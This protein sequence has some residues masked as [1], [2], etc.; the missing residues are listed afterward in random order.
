M[1]MNY[2]DIDGTRIRYE[3]R[4]EG[5]PVVLSYCL[6]GNLTFLHPQ[7]QVLAARYKVI[8]WEARGHGHSD[9]PVDPQAYGITRSAQDLNALL[10]HLEINRAHVGGLSMG[11]GIAGRFAQLYPARPL[12]LSILDSNT[13]AAQPV[14]PRM[15][16]VRE[17]TAALCDSGDMDAAAAYYLANSPA[18]KLF[19]GDNEDNRARLHAMVAATNAHGF[20]S[21][22]RAMRVPDSKPEDLALII[23]PTLVVA[24]E[25][26]PA[27]ASIRI[28]HE[29][30][31][32]S[33]LKVIPGAGH[34]SNLDNPDALVAV[35]LEFLA[36]ADRGV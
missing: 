8:L 12:S 1:R 5:T 14:A 7:A 27:I 36:N 17:H 16:E 35:M 10:D 9:S 23:A 24:G 11:G 6:G 2:A 32:G 26:D 20:A 28:T 15:R 33:V 18:Y 31:P 3:V 25:H 19:D 4:G 13:A 21:T 22:L 34:L 29:K 30:I